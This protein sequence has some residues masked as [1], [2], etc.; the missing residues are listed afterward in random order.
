MQLYFV[1][2]CQPFVAR[3]NVFTVGVNS[4]KVKT[5]VLP[6]WSAVFIVACV[7]V[8]MLYFMV[9]MVMSNSQN[10]PATDIIVSAE[11][12][13]TGTGLPSEERITAIGKTLIEDLFADDL[14]KSLR[15]RGRIFLIAKEPNTFRY[16][17]AVLCLYRDTF[18]AVNHRVVFEVSETRYDIISAE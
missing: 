9:G 10:T 3:N 4:M 18:T 12:G 2:C 17:L 8:V 1:Q 14:A 11:P 16:E 15:V 6:V 5:F 13:S 7:C